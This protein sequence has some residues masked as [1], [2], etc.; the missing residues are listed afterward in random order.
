M[1]FHN[2]GNVP[3]DLVRATWMEMA[4]HIKWAFGINLGDTIRARTKH[5]R[6][7]NCAYLPAVQRVLPIRSSRI[8]I[9][10]ATIFSLL[11]PDI[12]IAERLIVQFSVAKTIVHEL[13]VSILTVPK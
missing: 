10:T 9:S 1:S 4:G 3:P 5:T 8:E 13:C 11:Y 12:S 6:H 7:T 2:A